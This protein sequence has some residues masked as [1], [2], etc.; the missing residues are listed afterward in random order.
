MS[1]DLLIV[2]M[3]LSPSRNGFHSQGSCRWRNR[4]HAQCLSMTHPGLVDESSVCAESFFMAYNTRLDDMLAI[5]GSWEGLEVF[6]WEPR[7]LESG[8]EDRLRKDCGRAID[9]HSE[10]GDK[11]ED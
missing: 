10:V 9:I 6:S 3:Q 7:M 1:I 8:M 11:S 5:L 4:T 2:P